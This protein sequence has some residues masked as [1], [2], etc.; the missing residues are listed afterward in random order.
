[1]P[2]SAQKKPRRVSDQEVRETLL[3]M[4]RAAGPEG[5][6]KPE[7]VA[8]RILP[9]HWRTLLNRIRIESRHQAHAGR[10]VILRK[11]KPADPDDFK[12]LYRLRVTPAGLHE[13]EE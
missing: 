7:A 10:L 9:E 4:C 8:R 12:G 3:Q 1:M 13:E 6:V 11:G 5:A 2:K